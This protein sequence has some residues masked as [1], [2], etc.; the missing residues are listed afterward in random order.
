M[1]LLHGENEGVNSGDNPFE[2]LDILKRFTKL[3]YWL[4][5]GLLF[6][7]VLLFVGFIAVVKKP[8]LVITIDKLG[9][10]VAIKDYEKRSVAVTS[11]DIRDF[12]NVFLK[13]YVGLR[14][15][16]VIAQLEKAFNMM[17]ENLKS[18][19]MKSL[20]ENNTVKTVQ[21]AQIRNA[22]TLSK[23]NYEEIGDKIYINGLA[24]IL[25]TK[26]LDQPEEAGVQ[27]KFIVDITLDKVARSA[28]Y[29]YGIVISNM[30][31]RF[32]DEQEKINE[33]FEH[34]TEQ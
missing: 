12:V 26:P 20:E 33:S 15:D 28:M 29:P 17:D 34:I 1:S 7:N 21:A 3:A 5:G 8:P 14:S 18:M 6:I 13:N 30:S 10:A 25:E 23:I 4:F 24:G 32:N 19:L 22:V 9:E 16:L 2:L 27:K 31:I 11:E